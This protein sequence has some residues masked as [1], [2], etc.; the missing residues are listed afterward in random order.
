MQSVKN[1]QPCFNLEVGRC[2]HGSWETNDHAVCGHSERS[3]EQKTNGVR[4]QDALSAYPY[5]ALHYVENGT[6]FRF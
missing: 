2:G 3:R 5:P 6:H 1:G 4:R